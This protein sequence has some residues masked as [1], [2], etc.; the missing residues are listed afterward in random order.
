MADLILHDYQSRPAQ[1]IRA[2]W[3]SHR[4]VR[5]CLLLD[6]AGRYPP[7]VRARH[8]RNRRWLTRK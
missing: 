4:M 8:E 7:E 5:G 1:A 6:D 2:A 3:T